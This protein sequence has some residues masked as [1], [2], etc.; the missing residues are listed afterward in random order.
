MSR[1][2]FITREE[3]FGIVPFREDYPRAEELIKTFE[4]K[5]GPQQ[6]TSE[7]RS[8]VYD[9]M[10]G[11][12]LA[13]ASRTIQAL[14]KT[15][16]HFQTVAEEGIHA[17][18]Q[19]FASRTTE[20]LE[21]TGR[22]I[23][24]MSPGP[25]TIT[26]AGRGAFAKRSFVAG[27]VVTGTPVLYT[28]RP[29]FMRIYDGDWFHLSTSTPDKSKLK[30]HSIVM[31]YC[32][33]HVSSSLF[34]CPYGYGVNYINHN[35]TLA[36]VKMQWTP[37]GIMGQRSEYLH[38]SPEAMDHLSSPGLVMDIV[39][40]REIQPGEEL[41]LNYGDAWEQAW[42]DHVR[43]FEKRHKHYV[44]YTS[45]REWNALQENRILRTDKEQVHDPYPDNLE[46]RCLIE[47]GDKNLTV[48]EAKE[49]WTMENA[50]TSCSV[51]GRQVDDTRNML[52]QVW[53]KYPDN[54]DEDD[55]DHSWYASDWIVRETMQ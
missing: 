29:D 23:D 26:Q 6:F 16:S 15:V 37:A 36:N 49:L 50:G 11:V 30:T 12:K 47:I 1:S 40:T 8:D 28:H 39:A 35:Q 14:P 3:W 46:L 25:S 45:A 10:T 42:N 41:F 32:W 34:L 51:I 31:N 54:D 53:Y 2:W 43:D 27:D 18:Y 22:C 44:N 21:Q 9:F 24:T 5:V 17:Y 55:D 52:Y 38:Q 13:A 4:Q 7:L 33:N 20:E 19:K 48:A